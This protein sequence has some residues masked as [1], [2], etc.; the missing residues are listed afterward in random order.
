MANIPSDI[1][2]SLAPIIKGW[3]KEAINE[4][5]PALTE[6]HK[7]EKLKDDLPEYLSPGI[8]CKLLGLSLPTLRQHTKAGVYIA[9]RVG[10]RKIQY[11]K[12]EIEKALQARRINHFIKKSS[13]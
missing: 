5:V 3:V 12:S 4:L 7:P 6:V 11:K 13:L 8:A 10:K 1:L 2:D 9:Y